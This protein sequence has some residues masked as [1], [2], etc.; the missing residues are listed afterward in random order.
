[1]KRSEINRA[2]TLAKE[3][4]AKQCI[5]LPFF[6]YLKPEELKNTISK[7]SRIILNKLGWDVTDFGGDDF[8]NFGTVQFTL[9]NGTKTNIIKGTPYAEKVIILK[10]GQRLP[11]HFHFSKT[12]DIINRGGGILV[13]ELYNSLEDNSVDI[14][15]EVTVFCDGTERKVNAG[16]SFEIGPGNSITLPPRLY[17]LFRA[18]RNGGELVCG[19]VSTIN[20]DIEDNYFAESVKRFIEIGEDEEPIHLL[21]NE[22]A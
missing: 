7:H 21:C 19:E 13:M 8:D 18:G 1:M 20:D 15:N 2:I 12:E 17:H 11:L 22:Y 10:P 16:E 4:L 9:R 14:H 3:V 6:A 5:Y